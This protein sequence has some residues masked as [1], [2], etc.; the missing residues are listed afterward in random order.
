MVFYGPRTLWEA[1]RLLALL[2]WWHIRGRRR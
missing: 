1:A 2:W